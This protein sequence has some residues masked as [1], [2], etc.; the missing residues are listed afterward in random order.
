MKQEEKHNNSNSFFN[1][2]ES[3]ITVILFTVKITLLKRDFKKTVKKANNHFLL[4]KDWLLKMLWRQL[5][6]HTLSLF[7]NI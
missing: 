7:N 6:S 5:E 2:H 1:S 4:V 3:R